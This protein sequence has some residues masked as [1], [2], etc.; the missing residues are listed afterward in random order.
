MSKAKE[1]AVKKTTQAVKK[2][3][4]NEKMSTS[5]RIAQW[6]RDLKSELKK[7]VWPTKK[8]TANN[9]FVALVVTFASAIVLWGFDSLAQV[10][11]KTLISLVG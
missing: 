9:T 11:V 2:P 3:N 4:S 7:V 1:N 5:E 10:G 6:F 8:Q